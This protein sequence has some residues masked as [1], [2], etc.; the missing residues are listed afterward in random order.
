VSPVQSAA[1][2]TDV[3]S[4]ALACASAP[5]VSRQEQ[6]AGATRCSFRLHPEPARHMPVRLAI[7]ALIA[8]VAIACAKTAESATPDAIAATYGPERIA[9]ALDTALL[10]KADLGRIAGDTSAKLIVLEVSDFQCPYCKT[11]HDSTY[12]AVRREYVDVGKTRIAYVNLPLGMHQN[13]WPAAEAAMCASVQSQ[14]W[15]MHDSLFNAQ[16]RWERVAK[17][18]TM[19]ARFAQ[20]MALDATAYGK[21][22]SSHATRPLIASDAERANAAGITGTP[23]FI[24]GDSLIS[25]AY[26][27]P[28]FKRVIDANLAVKPR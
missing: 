13:A 9:V 21:C 20:S 27:F 25:G 28:D 1:W 6:T 4:D 19:F 8:A 5:P 15:A 18:D 10:R 26:P 2:R 22:I 3:A 7:G 24:I 23:A 17:P 12:P 14:F 16:R 11:F